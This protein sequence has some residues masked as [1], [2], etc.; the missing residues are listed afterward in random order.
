MGSDLPQRLAWRNPWVWYC[1]VSE[2]VCPCGICLG[3]R[4]DCQSLLNSHSHNM[5][6]FQ[7]FLLFRQVLCCSQIMSQEFLLLTWTFLLLLFPQLFLLTL[8]HLMCLLSKWWCQYYCFSFFIPS[9]EWA[10]DE[11]ARQCPSSHPGAM[12]WQQ[13]AAA[14]WTHVRERRECQT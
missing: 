1:R 9:V 11:S 14:T 12:G 13:A 5:Q 6:E 2:A 3:C 8:F 4:I 7:L 10:G